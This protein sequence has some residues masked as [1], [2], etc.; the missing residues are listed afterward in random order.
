MT[1]NPSLKVELSGHTDSMGEE[2]Y[3]V[4]LSKRRAQVVVDLLIKK[5]IQKDRMVSQGYGS[6]RPLAAN[7]KPDGTDNKEG[8]AKNRRTE[9]KILDN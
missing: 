5:G 2:A 6:A 7:K 4:I 3:N 8:R 9:L 1:E